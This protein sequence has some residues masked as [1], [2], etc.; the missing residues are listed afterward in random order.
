MA[1]LETLKAPADELSQQII[2]NV[3][4]T[5]TVYRGELCKGPA[6]K[7]SGQIAQILFGSRKI[8]LGSAPGEEEMREMEERISRFVESDNPI[9]INCLWGALKGYGRASLFQNP[10]I[11]EMMALRRFEDLHVKVS[12]LHGKGLRVNII[13]EDIGSSILNDKVDGTSGYIESYYNSLKDISSELGISG[14]IQVKKESELLA[15]KGFDVPAFLV[16]AEKNCNMFIDYLTASQQVDETAWNA[17]PEYIT[18]QKAGWKGTIPM[19]TREYYFQ[20]VATKNPNADMPERILYACKYLGLAFARYQCQVCGG[21]FADQ[22]GI[23][24]P[25]KASFVPYPPG[26]DVELKNGR[27]EYKVFDDKDNRRSVAPWSGCGLIVRKDGCL[28]SKIVGLNEY[29]QMVETGALPIP[30]QFTVRSKTKP[31]D[32]PARFMAGLIM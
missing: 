11:G 2:D 6:P 26:T 28:K 20:R 14:R 32:K 5:L 18:L 30:S 8:R 21:S 12:E 3:K 1:Y 13:M 16:Y 23:I 24:P 4:K 27:L 17:L 22:T 31:N 7:K 9:E 15:G 29:R 25:I 10:D 19:V